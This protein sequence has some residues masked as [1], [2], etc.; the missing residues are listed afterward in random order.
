MALSPLEIALV[1]IAAVVPPIVYVLWLRNA[2]ICDR[3]TLRMVFFAFLMGAAF[4]LGLAYVLETALLTAL[5]GQGGILT[6]PFWILDPQNPDVQ[7]VILACIVAPLVEEGTK[8][9]GIFYFRFKFTEI[10]NGMVYGAA[11]GLGFAALENML[12]EGNAMA[13]GISVFIGTALARALTSTALHASSSSL[14]GY[15]L[16]KQKMFHA[17]GKKASWIP[18]YFVAVGLHSLFNLLAVMGTL[19]NSD[20]VYIGLR[21]L[22]PD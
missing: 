5:F 10:E 11:V 16:A 9:L 14:M 15:G 18:Y 13:V 19:V 22:R 17:Q 8:G 6:R 4:S 7:L 21:P 2:E 12:Y 1:F 20:L 3:E